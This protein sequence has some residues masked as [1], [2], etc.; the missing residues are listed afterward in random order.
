MAVANAVPVVQPGTVVQPPFDSEKV[1]REIAENNKVQLDQF[2][3]TIMDHITKVVKPVA[4]APVS[5]S[6]VD[7]EYS[8]ELAKLGLDKDPDAANA[9]L[10]IAG[11]IAAKNAANLKTEV[12]TEMNN[13][14]DFKN[15]KA[16]MENDIAAK[17]PQIL[18]NTSKL[19]KETER[20]FANFSL[21]VKNSAEGTTLAIVQAA[22]NLGI[23]PIDLAALR[24]ADAINHTN[25]GGSGNIQRSEITE[26][27]KS[28][29]ALFGVKADVYEKKLKEVRARGLK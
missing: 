16:K 15:S 4:P 8:D 21:P 9:L 24:A 25:S 6:K 26:K 3:R 17:Y 7:G 2:Q 5:T 28:F 22:A 13:D 1:K 23:D 20:I 18:D 11:K 10:A 29:G 27:Q 14:I 12:K 19:W